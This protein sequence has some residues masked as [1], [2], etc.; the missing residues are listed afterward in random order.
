MENIVKDALEV[1]KSTA[2][3][4]VTFLRKTMQS[5]VVVAQAAANRLIARKPLWEAVMRS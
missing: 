5:S 1:T 4:P 3:G 2:I